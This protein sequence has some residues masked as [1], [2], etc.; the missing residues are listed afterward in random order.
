MYVDSYINA[1]CEEIETFLDLIKSKRRFAKDFA[2]YFESN[3]IEQ[4]A[5][6]AYL[7]R[8]LSNLDPEG[9][10]H[11]GNSNFHLKSTKQILS[12][13]EERWE[14]EGMDANKK[15]TQ[16]LLEAIN[17]LLAE[18]DGN[19]AVLPAFLKKIT[20]CDK[21]VKALS[22]SVQNKISLSWNGI[23]MML[24]MLNS[25]PQGMQEAQF[26]AILS[27]IKFHLQKIS[28]DLLS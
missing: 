23:I 19:T 17:G 11:Q 6:F 5:Q 20:E 10:L 13:I 24:N 27:P 25:F 18:I 15:Q 21:L 8:L 28:L 7:Q 22:P 1:L 4:T 9:I 14:C 12:W 16:H 3:A 2:I 26:F